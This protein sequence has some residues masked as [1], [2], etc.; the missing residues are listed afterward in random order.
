M[1][2]DVVGKEWH[3]TQ[4]K[5]KKKNYENIGNGLGVLANKD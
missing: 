1:S 3:G 5:K 4:K 2:H